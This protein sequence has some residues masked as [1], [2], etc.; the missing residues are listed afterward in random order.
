VRA[1]PVLWGGA[2]SSRCGEDVARWVE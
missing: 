2:G 1:R